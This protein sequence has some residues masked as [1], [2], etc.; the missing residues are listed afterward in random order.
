MVLLRRVAIGLAV[1]LL[2]AAVVWLARKLASHEDSG[3]KKQ[4]AKISLLPDTPPPPPPPPPKERKEE[5]PKSEPRPQQQ[6]DNT[7]KPP[8]SET[9]KMEGAAGNGPSAFSSGTVS[10]DYQGGPPNGGGGGASAS[11]RAAER[12]Y[13]GSVRQLLRD[14]MERQL[15]AEAGELQATFA[16]W[17]ASDGRISR[18][19]VEPT[20]VA[21]ATQATLNVA[22][23]RCADTLRLPAPNTVPQPLRFKLTLRANG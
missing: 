14:E 2:L 6:P 8:A 7:P 3:P 20:G 21:A 12:L 4:V 9:L 10:K 17:V 13:A 5:P 11:D 15:P 23:Q 22:L 16:L 19:E 18:W 1:L